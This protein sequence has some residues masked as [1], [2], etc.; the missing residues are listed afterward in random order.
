[1]TATTARARRAEYAYTPEEDEEM[2]HIEE[3]NTGVSE[4]AGG[5]MLDARDRSTWPPEVLRHVQ[6]GDMWDLEVADDLQ[7]YRENVLLA[8]VTERL[9]ETFVFCRAAV[10]FLSEDV[11]LDTVA[12]RVLDELSSW[13][14]GLLQEGVAHALEL[15]PVVAAVAPFATG[16]E[17]LA[18][19]RAKLAALEVDGE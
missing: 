6:G 12:G 11:A 8:L 17:M 2:V 5:R 3:R 14:D 9:G 13:L 4:A 16:E 1:M 7:Q 10:R 18:H 19:V 15:A